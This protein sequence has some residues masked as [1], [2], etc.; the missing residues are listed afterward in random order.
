M[1]RH[2]TGDNSIAY[3]AGTTICAAEPTT[4]LPLTTSPLLRVRITCFPI[5][6]R[7]SSSVIMEPGFFPPAFHAAFLGRSPF[8]GK[9]P[10]AGFASQPRVD[11]KVVRLSTNPVPAPAAL[12]PPPGYNGGMK[13]RTALITLSAVAL[14]P[15]VGQGAAVKQ[16][17]PSE[18]GRLRPGWDLICCGINPHYPT[19]G[20]ETIY[21]PYERL[22]RTDTVGAFLAAYDRLSEAPRRLPADFCLYLGQR[23]PSAYWFGFANPADRIDAFGRIVPA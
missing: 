20:R 18:W 15:T 17:D 4:N 19:D 5:N 10:L 6:C 8:M 11:S 16:N 3:G 23:V 1:A 21:P 9:A 13:R 14:L 12:P 7:N 2:D 22:A